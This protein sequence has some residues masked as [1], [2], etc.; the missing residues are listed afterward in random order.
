MNHEF[1]FNCSSFKWETECYEFNIMVVRKTIYMLM[2][3]F[4]SRGYLYL[5]QVYEHFGMKW[6][7]ANRNDLIRY[8]ECYANE[9]PL[10]Y[11][12]VDE[13]ENCV[14]IMIDAYKEEKG[15]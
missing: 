5:N 4:R 12:D 7:P 14:H 15:R 2:G 3:L 13:N 6:N 1:E 9:T 10:F 11:Y 8:H